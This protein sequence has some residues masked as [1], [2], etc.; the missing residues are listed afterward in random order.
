[1]PDITGAELNSNKGTCATV[2]LIKQVCLH[3]ALYYY[4]TSQANDSFL[5]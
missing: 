2:I 1:M 4:C 5:W 3:L